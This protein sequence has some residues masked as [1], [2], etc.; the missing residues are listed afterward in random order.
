MATYPLR[1]DL[2]EIDLPLDKIYLDPNNPRF[3][4][5]DSI[6]VPDGEITGEA[7]QESARK[8][9]VAEFGVNKL[10]QSMEVNGYL[11][12]DRVIVREFAPGMFVVL[13]GNRRICAAKLV[14][15]YSNEGEEISEEVKSTF[16]SIPCL[17]YVGTVSDASWIFQGLRHITGIS[18]WSAFNKAKLLVSQMEEEEGLTL[19]DVGKRFGLT[20]YGAGQWA[21]GY[22]AF[23]QATEASDYVEEVDERSYPYFQ[24]L[25]S[26]S[27]AL[28]REWLEWNESASRFENELN[29]NEFISWLYPRDPDK[30]ADDEET[31]ESFGEW[32]KRPLKTRDDIRQI[33]YLLRE[34]KSAFERFRK[35]LDIEQAYAQALSAKYEKESREKKDVEEEFFSTVES[36]V[37]V[38]KNIPLRLLTEADTRIRVVE[39]IQALQQALKPILEFSHGK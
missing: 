25:F 20:A 27:S 22:Y 10:R 38:L 29:F 17:Q 26:R 6:P 32:E 11:P 7:T 12:I 3:V 36:C 21:R 9:L 8:T 39:E 13:E 35:E 2:K 5:K 30:A 23:K 15:N 14:S 24:E 18:D 31:N 4:T 1:N 19:T 16:N 34:D 28:V 37:R 33:A